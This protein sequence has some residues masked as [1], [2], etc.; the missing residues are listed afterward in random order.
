MFDRI[1]NIQEVIGNNNI[2]IN[3]DITVDCEILKKVAYQLLKTELNNLTLEAKEQMQ[4]WVNEG[5]HS[6]LKQMV[7]RNIESKLSEFSS[8]S[9][10]F[11]FYTMLKGYS[12]V[13]TIEQRDLLVDAFI[14]RIQT[15]WDSSEK[16]IIDSALEVLPKLS[17][18]A[19]STI[20]LLQIRHQLVN[21]QVRFML[22]QYFANL[23]PLVEKMSLVTTL[24][25]EYLKQE[26]LILPLP[27]LNMSVSL[28]E[29]L[30]THYDL[31]FRHSLKEG[32]YDEYCRMHPEAREAVTDNPICA[33]MMCI[34]GTRNNETSFCCANSNLLIETLKKRHQEYIIPHVEAL[35]RMMP[36][37]TKEEIRNYFLTLSPSW[38]RLFRLF[39]T[40]C[41]RMYTLSITGNYI[42]G[43]ILAKVCHGEP[44]TLTDYKK[45]EFL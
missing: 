33:C 14:D 24:D 11:A 20:G 45:N 19:L 36:P 5:V 6:V 32:V 21:T 30:L 44:L 3:G 41:F 16:M 2:I 31:F 28:E 13:E 39:S 42:G 27:G 8:P 17:P 38:E 43:K 23:T 40:E 22:H 1:Q 26:R 18:Q 15:N 7:S 10:Q 37:F 9:T 4:G 35:K 34:D 12:Y 25:I 29:I